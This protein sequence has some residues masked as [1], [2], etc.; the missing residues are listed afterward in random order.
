MF[1][2]L[3]FLVL[4]L[5]LFPDKLLR[6]S[7]WAMIGFTTLGS[8]VFGLATIVQCRPLEKAWQKSLPGACF[9]QTGFWYSHA[10]FNTFTDL[11]IFF[12]PVHQILK[13]Q[14]PFT[15]KMGLILIFATGA[16]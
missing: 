2:K 16:L 8:V 5:R 4:F 13:L 15:Q 9:N 6:L 1:T 11:I 14:L 10:A 3:S 7:T 12:M